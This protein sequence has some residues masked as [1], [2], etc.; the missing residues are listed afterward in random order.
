MKLFEEHA[1]EGGAAETV[2]H[3]VVECEDDGSVP[4]HGKP[5]QRQTRIRVETALE[6]RFENRFN[7]GEV[8]VDEFHDA[9][10]VERGEPD[11]LRTPVLV[12]GRRG[13]ARSEHHVVA[14]DFTKGRE[15]GSFVDDGP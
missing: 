10:Q 15:E 3:G 2:A 14:H 8:I 4:E 13:D 1:V 9:V 11:P 12:V 7:V 5:P 6:L